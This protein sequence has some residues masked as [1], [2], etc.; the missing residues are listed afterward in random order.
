MAEPSPGTDTRLDE[1]IYQAVRGRSG[2]AGVDIR[3][4]L[5]SVDSA[6]RWVLT[7]GEL[8][9]GL[10]RLSDGGLIREVAVGRYEGTGSRPGIA[11]SG[12]SRALYEAAVAEYRI[13]FSRDVER[14]MRSRIMRGLVGLARF[15]HRLTGG[16]FGLAPGWVDL[17]A[18]AIAFA[19]ERILVPFGASADDLVIEADSLVVPVV[20]GNI[21]LDRHTIADHARRALSKSNTRRTVVLRFRDGDEVLSPKALGE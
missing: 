11:Y 4:I 5:E 7:F 3:T 10:R 19:V 8:D 16:R 17:D 6:E 20:E 12:I 9:G 21:R 2:R 1:L 14:V 18:V 13:G 15:A